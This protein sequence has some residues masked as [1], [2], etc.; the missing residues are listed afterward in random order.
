MRDN[1][2][3]DNLDVRAASFL[4]Q[5]DQFGNECLVTCG[6]AAGPDGI[7]IVFQCKIH[8][9]RGRLEKRARNHFEA[10]VGK[11]AGNDV[12]PA[13]VTIL[14]HLCNHQLWRTA[15]APFDRLHTFDNLRITV[16]FSVGRGINPAHR[17]GHG[18]VAPIGVFHRSGYFAQRRIVAGRFNRQ[19]KQIALSL[20]RPSG[21]RIERGLAR[22][23][24]PIRAHFLQPRNL[25]ATHRMVVDIERVDLVFLVTAV[26]VYTDDDG[27]A[28]VNGGLLGRSRF[29]NLRLWLTAGDIFGHP[30]RRFDFRE[31]R[32][33]LL[34][35]GGRE[36][37][38]IV[39]T[40]QRIRDIGN[41]AFFLDHQ[42]RVTRDT[43]T[44]IS[45]QRNRLVERVRVQRLRAAQNCGHRLD[46]GADDVV[47]RILLL[48]AYA[49]GLAVRAQHFRLFGL[50]PQP[51]H[52]FM[53]KRT[54][55]AHL[56]DFHEKV[57]A[58][59]P[60]E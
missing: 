22:E 16:I 33:R 41:A 45:R 53:P 5:V 39:A 24:I 9:F 26:F 54:A 60:E 52:H 47:V 43:G 35:Q 57:H 59:A 37:F 3:C 50:R 19:A 56:G 27:L 40:A 6:K 1:A 13:V 11:G 10:H 2:A 7:D 29:L 15:E 21:E 46:R 30:T 58:D 51:F 25:A 28:P 12:S 31:Q 8:C 20:R 23:F 36:A 34:E 4:Q 32:A 44:E 17:L 18:I 38:D 42:L 49:T 14:T 48:Q 55:R